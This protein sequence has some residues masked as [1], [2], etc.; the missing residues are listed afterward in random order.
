[1][2]RRYR[3]A[4]SLLFLTVLVAAYV[5][6]QPEQPAPVAAYTLSCAQLAA[7]STSGGSSHYAV[8][9]AA[10]IAA[11]TG[12]TQTS[13]HYTVTNPMSPYANNGIALAMGTTMRLCWSAS[14]KPDNAKGFEVSRSSL[15]DDLRFCKLTPEP[16]QD[17]VYDDRNLPNGSYVYVVSLVDAQDQRIQW[18][19]PFIGAISAFTTSETWMLY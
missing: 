9:D 18:T 3:V 10:H 12:E 2:F 4:A 6:S 8:E 7:A 17:T 13:S 19:T 1:M 11:T 15:C 14:G 16:I 5:Q